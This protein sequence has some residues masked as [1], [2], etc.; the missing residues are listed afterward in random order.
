MARNLRS[1]EGPSNHWPEHQVGLEAIRTQLQRILA[2]RTFADTDRL[3]RLLQFLVEEAICG[4]GGE[5]KEYLVGVEVFARPESFDPRSDS[6]VRVQA[7]NLRKLLAQY[8]ASEGSGDRVLISIPKGSY[9]PVFAQ[10]ALVNTSRR[11]RI[12]FAVAAALVVAVGLW[13]GVHWYY[14]SGMAS[15]AVLPFTNLSGEPRNDYLAEAVSEDLTTGLAKI[16]RLRVVARTSTSRFRGNSPDVRD[17]GRQLRVGALLEGSLRRTGH[18]VIVTAQ[19]V[20]ANDGYHLWSES[21]ER[22]LSALPSI[23]AEIVAAVVTAR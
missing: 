19:L 15:I 20:S 1:V 16:T 3:R 14:S 13:A 10:P 11:S 4:R 6:I 8:Y 23:Q 7:R 17:I 18:T 5:L 2:S 21:F 12:A 9:A 22:P